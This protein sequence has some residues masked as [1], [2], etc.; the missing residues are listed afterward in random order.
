[1][2]TVH[3]FLCFLIVISTGIVP[4]DL[5]SANLGNSSADGGMVEV[6]PIPTPNGSLLENRQL[7]INEKLI[8]EGKHFGFSRKM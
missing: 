6:T 8:G 7:G 5:R 4:G 3:F 1:M 2:K